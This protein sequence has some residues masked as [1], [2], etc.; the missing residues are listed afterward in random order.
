MRSGSALLSLSMTFFGLLHYLFYSGLLVSC[1]S[2]VRVSLWVYV[3]GDVVPGAIAS[4]D[5][6]FIVVGMLVKQR[7]QAHVVCTPFLW[8][9]SLALRFIGS[10]HGKITVVNVTVQAC[11]LRFLVTLFVLSLCFFFVAAA[12]VLFSFRVESQVPCLL[13]HS[14]CLC[15]SS[16]FIFILFLLG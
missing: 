7:A 16:T 1:F 10:R 14:S 6:S 5:G 15:G 12:V 11:H 2:L 13:A 4:P 8:S 9:I 3:G